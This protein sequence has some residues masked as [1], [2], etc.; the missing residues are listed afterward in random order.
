MLK[1]ASR[2]RVRPEDIIEWCKAHMAAYKYPRLI[3]FVDSLPKSATGKVM[4][5]QLQ[6]QESAKA[7]PQRA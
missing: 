4:W 6:E 3:E 2:G 1:A 7:E 5:R